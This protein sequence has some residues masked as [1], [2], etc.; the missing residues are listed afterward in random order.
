MRICWLAGNR[1]QAPNGAPSA[2][3]GSDPPWVRALLIGSGLTILGLVLFLP[4]AVVFVEAFAKGVGTYW[5]A[6]RDPDT[7]AAIRL[8]LQVAASAV[9]ANTLFGLAAA[10]CLSR[11]PFPGRRFLE[12][13]I[14]LPFTVSPVI[15]GL[16]FVLL[17]GRQGWLGPWLAERGWQ[18]IFAPPGIVVATLFV[19]L[20]IV[21]KEL[22]P[23]MRG[24]GTDEEEAALVLGASGWQIF[25]RITLP[26]IRRAL[27]YG[28]I[29]CN[30]RAMG[31]FGAVSVVSGHIRGKTNTV[32]LHVE[33]LYNEYD[34][35][36][37]F[38]VASLLTLLA[39]GTLVLKALLDWREGGAGTAP[40][41]EGGTEG[42]H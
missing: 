6:L 9:A 38:A 23:L 34:F 19:T 14:D 35:T 11:A 7:L 20:P 36:G 13:L 31:E 16:V 17:F 24:Q 28:V 22:I 41:D 26:R 3:P 2:P 4:L 29:L 12:G 15:A 37:A 10:W 33:M 25:W 30:A 39:L 32:P 8:T 42:E 5:Q 1:L 21:A 27:L 40:G 18:V